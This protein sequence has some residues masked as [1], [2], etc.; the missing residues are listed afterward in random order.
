MATLAVTETVV[1][2]AATIT[3]YV[4]VAGAKMRLPRETVSADSDGSSHLQSAAVHVS[5]VVQAV[6]VGA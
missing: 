1:A 3:A 4:V 5:D 6:S 2:A